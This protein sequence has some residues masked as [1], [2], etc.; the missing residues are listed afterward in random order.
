MKIGII[1]TGIEVGELSESND[2]L[3]KKVLNYDIKKTNK[4]LD[5]WIKQKYGINKRVKTNRLP[6]DLASKACFHALKKANIDVSQI[7]FLILNTTSGDYKQPTTAT[8]VQ[9][10]IGMKEDSFALEINMPC[11]GNIYGISVAYSFI[12]SGLGKN[13]LVVGVDR[14]SSII[15]ETDYVLGGMFGDAASACIIGENPQWV[16]SDIFLKSKSDEE[17]SLGI[18]SSGSAL[19]LSL[20]SISNKDHLLKM[21]G[22]ETSDFIEESV[23]ET[24]FNLLNKSG[25]KVK[26]VDQVITHQASKPI[27]CR[28]LDYLG[29]K[30]SQYFFTVEDYG[31]TSSASIIL[32][33]DCFLN[34]NKNVNNIF[35]IGMGSGLNWGGIVLRK[36]T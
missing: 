19:P 32:T 36:N 35:L 25:L 13:G 11:A 8:K 18:K 33:L 28:A 14:M 27:I 31:N 24:F 26:E 2:D 15:D 30:E 7:D 16:V 21:K 12:N 6:S 22:K 9:N 3:E 5:E 17:R 34:F 29:L 1:S 4:K 20:E 10:L 23:K